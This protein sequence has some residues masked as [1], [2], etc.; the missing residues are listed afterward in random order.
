MNLFIPL[1]MAALLLLAPPGAL[2]KAEGLEVESISIGEARLLPRDLPW[3][4]PPSRERVAPGM[5]CAELYGGRPVGIPCHLYAEHGAVC[6]NRSGEE[7]SSES[8][9][10]LSVYSYPNSSA[11]HTVLQMWREGKVHPS[12][13]EPV[14]GALGDGAVRWVN[15]GAYTHATYLIAYRNFAVQ[16]YAR[17][18]DAPAELNPT[19]MQAVLDRLDRVDGSPVPRNPAVSPALSPS[20]PAA[21]RQP[22][23]EALAALAALGV[24]PLLRRPGRI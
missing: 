19:L 6:L 18:P 7:C 8:S 21:P 22:G 24:A 2:A 20:P 1:L 3:S 12:S 16:Y 4:G 15:I 5:S 10:G 11:V 13:A 14:P 23:F 9:V 17:T